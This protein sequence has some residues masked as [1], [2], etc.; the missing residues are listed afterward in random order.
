MLAYI[1]IMKL[2]VILFSVYFLSLS[3]FPCGDEYT[4]VKDKDSITSCNINQQNQKDHSD[5]CSPL[6]YCQCCHI[7]SLIVVVT[8]KNILSPSYYDHNFGIVINFLEKPVSP[9]LQPPQLI[10]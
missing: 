4:V 5:L 8:L 9:I 2:T 1:C 10:S 6:C 7:Q 3:F